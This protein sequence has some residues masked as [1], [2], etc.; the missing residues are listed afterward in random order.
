MTF[1]R[2][3]VL[4]EISY[5]AQLTLHLYLQ[6]DLQYIQSPSGEYPDAWVGILR[7]HIE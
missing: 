6:P 3:L 7:L 5:V 1:S 2:P 4:F